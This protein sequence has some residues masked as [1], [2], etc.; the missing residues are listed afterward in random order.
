MFDQMSMFDA[1]E[2]EAIAM[3]VQRIVKRGGPVRRSKNV[4]VQIEFRLKAARKIA[5]K[6]R[7]REDPDER[8]DLH[9]SEG[10]VR[11]LYIEMFRDWEERFPN[12]SLP[13]EVRDYWAWMLADSTEPFCF[14]NV[15]IAN[16]YRDPDTFIEQLPAVAPDW[17]KKEF[18]LN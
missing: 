17:I 11:T 3:K 2:I 18:G 14:R 13:N 15:L 9:W 5:F 7:F 6:R 12:V 16:G 4:P 8:N 10:A 1:G